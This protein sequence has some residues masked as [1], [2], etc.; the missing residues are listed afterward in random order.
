MLEIDRGFVTSTI[1]LF[2][3][4]FCHNSFRIVLIKPKG[5][6]V[7]WQIFRSVDVYPSENNA[8][9]RVLLSS[10]CTEQSHWFRKRLGRLRYWL[11]ITTSS[12][13][14]SNVIADLWVSKTKNISLSHTNDIMKWSVSLVWQMIFDSLNLNKNTD[15]V[16][17]TIFP[18]LSCRISLPIIYFTEIFDFRRWKKIGSLL[19]NK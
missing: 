19:S 10:M 14:I 1:V 15:F 6:S 11:S 9:T 16:S 12:E 7:Q 17:I 5:F 4:F 2:L 13:I 3:F 18:L 8:M